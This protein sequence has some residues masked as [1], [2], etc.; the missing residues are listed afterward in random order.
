MTNETTRFQLP[1]LQPAQAQKHVTVNEALMRLGW[2]DQRRPGKHLCP[3]P[4]RSRDR[5]A[6]LGRPARGQWPMGW[7]DWADCGWRQW[8][9]GLHGPL[10]RDACLCGRTRGRGDL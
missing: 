2:P 5:R 4:P 8:W 6:V 10:A 9:L 7:A 1:L 3:D